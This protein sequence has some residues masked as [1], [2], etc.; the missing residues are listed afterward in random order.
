MHASPDHHS[1]TEER[2]IAGPPDLAM[3]RMAAGRDGGAPLLPHERGEA[4]LR[5]RLGPI[6]RGGTAAVPGAMPC[7]VPGIGHLVDLA[8]PDAVRTSVT[9]LWSRLEAA[10]C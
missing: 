5:D 6:E 9:A 3:T 4:F 2:R 1:A 8:T 10:A 7:L